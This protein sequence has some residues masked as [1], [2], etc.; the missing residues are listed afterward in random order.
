[1]AHRRQKRRFRLVRG[2][3]LNA[4]RL[5]RVGAL[6]QFIDQ[7]RILHRNDGLRCEIL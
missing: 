6:A 3:R 1:M 2:L 5:G 7:P 4:R